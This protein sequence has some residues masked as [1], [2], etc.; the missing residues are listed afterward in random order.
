M[1]ILEKLKRA[2]LNYLRGEYESAYGENINPAKRA[3]LQAQQDRLQHE[4]DMANKRAYTGDS[5]PWA[6][7][8]GL[9][10]SALGSGITYAPLL[11]EAVAAPEVAIPYALAASALN[12]GS[13]N[14]LQKKYDEKVL[15]IEPQEEKGSYIGNVLSDAAP[16][17]L[18]P[19]AKG[20]GGLIGG[21]E[22]AAL[23][24][25]IG[26]MGAGVI[27]EEGLRN[28][29]NNVS[30]QLENLG[31][32]TNPINVAAQMIG[33]TK[34]PGE[35][36]GGDPFKTFADAKFLATGVAN[37]PGVSEVIRKVT[38]DT[39]SYGR[40][41]NE[42]PNIERFISG[43]EANRL[44]PEDL[45][46]VKNLS[47]FNPDTGMLGGGI[48]SKFSGLSP[49]ILQKLES[50]GNAERL[51]GG[52]GAAD[53]ANNSVIKNLGN[54]KESWARQ[55]PYV[56]SEGIVYDPSKFSSFDKFSNFVEGHEVGH[57][58][59]G[60]NENLADAFGKYYAEGKAG[61][62]INNRINSAPAEERRST[63]DP[64]IKLIGY[65]PD[66]QKIAQEAYIYQKAK[67]AR[68][69]KGSGEPI[70]LGDGTNNLYHGFSPKLRLP[71]DSTIYAGDESAA[72]ARRRA[73]AFADRQAAGGFN[74]RSA[75]IYT[76]DTGERALSLKV[77]IPPF[78]SEANK[79]AFMRE[80]EKAKKAY[81]KDML[82]DFVKNNGGKSSKV[83]KAS[84]EKLF[85]K[86]IDGEQKK[87]IWRKSKDILGF[88]A[89][90]PNKKKMFEAMTDFL[91][92]TGQTDKLPDLIKQYEE[93]ALETQGSSS[94]GVKRNTPLI[95]LLKG[96]TPKRGPTIGSTE[97]PSQIS[98]RR[99]E[100]D[101][102]QAMVDRAIE[103]GR[104]ANYDDLSEAEKEQIDNRNR[105][106][107]FSN[108][109]DQD[110][111][112][113]ISRALNAETRNR[114]RDRVRERESR[115]SLEKYLSD[116][117]YDFMA[118]EK[119]KS[120]WDKLKEKT[121]KAPEMVNINVT[122][123]LEKIFK[124]K[125]ENEAKAILK[126]LGVEYDRDTKDVSSKETLL[127]YLYRVGGEEVNNA[128][129]PQESV[130]QPNN[131]GD[132]DRKSL[133][134]VKDE[135]EQGNTVHLKYS[136]RL[137]KAISGWVI[138][139]LDKIFS[140]KKAITDGRLVLHGEQGQKV[141]SAIA[142]S[143]FIEMTRDPIPTN[144][145]KIVD[146]PVHEVSPE[147]KELMKT[148]GVNSEAE[149]IRRMFPSDR[150]ITTQG[151]AKM[152]PDDP[153][154]PFLAAQRE[155]NRRSAE[156]QR[157]LAKMFDKLSKADVSRR[158][159]NIR[160]AKKVLSDV[161]RIMEDVPKIG[162]E[163]IGFVK[164]DGVI[165]PVADSETGI[166]KAG[167]ISKSGLL[168]TD[169]S[170]PDAIPFRA[171]SEIAEHLRK[172]EKDKAIKKLEDWKRYS[173]NL[174][175]DDGYVYPKKWDET[176]KSNPVH[177]VGWAQEV[178]QRALEKTGEK[179]TGAID[180]AS[181]ILGLSK[182][183]TK[184]LKEFANVR[185]MEKAEEG[186]LNDVNKMN[187]KLPEYTESKLK[188][189]LKNGTNTPE[190]Y[191]KAIKTLTKDIARLRKKGFSFMAENPDKKRVGLWY[192]LT[193]AARNLEEV[194]MKL[195][196]SANEQLMSMILKRNS[197][198]GFDKESSLIT[199][200]VE[201]IK[202]STIESDVL[203]KKMINLIGENDF[204]DKLKTIEADGKGLTMT[205]GHRLVTDPDFRKSNWNK[206]S[207]DEKFI[208]EH[209]QKIM[210]EM[211]NTKSIMMGKDFKPRENYLKNVVREIVS[212]D[213]MNERNYTKAE[214]LSIAKRV[215]KNILMDKSG[216]KEIPVLPGEMGDYIDF[217]RTLRDIAIN[218][219]K[220]ENGNITK[221]KI[222]EAKDIAQGMTMRQLGR[223]LNVGGEEMGD[224]KI[225]IPVLDTSTLKRFFP[226]YGE[227]TLQ[228]LP[229]ILR[230]TLNEYD[231]RTLN[232]KVF[233][234]WQELYKS[235]QLKKLLSPKEYQ[236]VKNVLDAVNYSLA[237]TSAGE[238]IGARTKLS[239][240][241][242]KWFGTHT[243]DFPYPNSAAGHYITG[244]IY[245]NLLSNPMFMA[246]NST[247]A[248]IK[249]APYYNIGSKTG[250]KDYA[251]TVLPITFR[252][253]KDVVKGALFGGLEKNKMWNLAQEYIPHKKNLPSILTSE[254]AMGGKL[255]E[256]LGKIFGKKNVR[257]VRR[258][259]Q[260]IPELIEAQEEVNNAA[261]FLSF[262]ERELR[263]Q[264]REKK[265]GEYSPSQGLLLDKVLNGE[266]IGVSDKRIKKA[267]GEAMLKLKKAQ[268][269]TSGYGG[270]SQVGYDTE[271][272]IK[273]NSSITPLMIM[274]KM[275]M[276]YP[277]TIAQAVISNTAENMSRASSRGKLRKLSAITSPVGMIM[278]ATFMSYALPQAAVNAAKGKDVHL[279]PLTDMGKILEV[280]TRELGF[281]N[282]IMPLSFMED[283]KNL[284]VAP[285]KGLKGL[286]SK[287]LPGYFT[288]RQIGRIIN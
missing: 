116:N 40:F 26:H 100:N 158:D 210:K 133:R 44:S 54:I 27:G 137:E 120:Y 284:I 171:L 274:S 50:S 128:L 268:G 134:K 213:Q 119:K 18:S 151:Y 20:I 17:L 221:E 131:S 58:M 236:E 217:Y 23:G 94:R 246:I 162:Y 147:T 286:A 6:M 115:R 148:E 35:L 108:L 111:G 226:D 176:L 103:D 86:K 101:R 146:S 46:Q 262:A 193:S 13:R 242:D 60:G 285:S 63:V 143:G 15:G 175:D 140:K 222:L 43:H 253:A 258:F 79:A 117:G 121:G 73:Q 24:A 68:K 238:Q 260:S 207:E 118:E 204:M 3:F 141:S 266:K 42:H 114:I 173:R 198:K 110:I 96:K 283:A 218:T 169:A 197:S 37:T 22:G 278:A 9:T 71:Y 138:K 281:R 113:N 75:P 8:K 270:K 29:Y 209:T 279:D 219:M 7:A 251:T 223:E 155:P 87:K 157:G 188:D 180:K 76:A 132:Y 288:A 57:L 192:R 1:D 241:L 267:Y 239:M 99:F 88:M 2:K 183:T 256:G 39:S 28:D 208:V 149:L 127:N 12:I 30:S 244:Q 215:N 250:L 233:S 109:R 265:G 255:E 277:S 231:S 49:D 52:Y 55:E 85:G 232:Q 234:R 212:K 235:K 205:N 261:I 38:P 214:T 81:G 200:L 287:T 227:Y 4:A 263:Q 56:G 156:E 166:P 136:R 249:T 247:D 112:R 10:S 179:G 160:R 196:G 80:F 92:K 69:G 264:V 66:V 105:T 248:F 181:E 139:P 91:V 65:N 95:N 31:Q 142:N 126:K 168:T 70:N 271:K 47:D 32:S 184:A 280:S 82:A 237:F 51:K 33:G 98:E 245:T 153:E 77:G 225:N 145:E 104:P 240:F 107:A 102:W 159:E 74:E 59:N 93:G 144:V 36:S 124:Q 48:E 203:R 61:N 273:K 67:E 45:F 282:S 199:K 252:M 190:L 220:D 106:E 62:F 167:R 84:W 129:A 165:K 11:L 206:L 90:D 182:E 135:I 164:E 191:A 125:T 14:Y 19:A 202:S 163:D 72:N 123:E 187:H 64:L 16:L 83:K 78:S 161:K 224:M 21:A 211:A 257:R 172:G 272:A 254:H 243:S 186:F 216:D 97:T 228:D 5:E 195:M 185:S 194:S 25:R 150:K 152:K 229:S 189:W 269:K 154:A 41:L 201:D 174:P 34:V 122:S 130:Y 275:F 276:S 178:L 170:S 259:W 177:E 53:Y 89:A 230:R